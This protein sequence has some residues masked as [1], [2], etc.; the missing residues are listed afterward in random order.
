MSNFQHGFKAIR[1]KL[2]ISFVPQFPIDTC[3]HV[4]IYK[5]SLKDSEPY[6]NIDLSNAANKIKIIELYGR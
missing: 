2:Q 6:W 1:T 4:Q 5:F 3:I